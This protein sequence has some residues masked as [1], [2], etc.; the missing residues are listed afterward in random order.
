MSRLIFNLGAFLDKEKLKT[1]GSNFTTWF[2]TLR[3]IPAPHKM[4]YVLDAAIGAAPNGDASNDVKNVYQM[5]VDDAS[6]V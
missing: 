6:F 5:K 2:Y 3:I 4:G 1:D